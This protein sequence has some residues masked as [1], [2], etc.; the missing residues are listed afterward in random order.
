M[1]K[2]KQKNPFKHLIPLLPGSISNGA[3][4]SQNT[5]ITKSKWAIILTIETSIGKTGMMVNN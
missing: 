4:L 2:N 5:T 1:N 3:S